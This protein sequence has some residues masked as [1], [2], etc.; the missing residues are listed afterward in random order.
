MEPKSVH[1]LEK[2]LEKPI[3]E[4]ICRLG[5]KNLPLLPSHGTVQ[6]MAKAAVAVYETAVEI[7][8]RLEDGG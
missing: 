1:K 4:V 5:L 6:M 8:E 7:H 3:L 2:A